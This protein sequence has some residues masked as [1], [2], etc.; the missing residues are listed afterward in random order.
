MA[1]ARGFVTGWW[2]AQGEDHEQQSRKLWREFTRLRPFW[3]L[4]SR[5]E[6]AE[7]IKSILLL[8]KKRETLPALR[9][10]LKNIRSEIIR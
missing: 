6:D 4:Y 8:G 10:I 9:Q 7:K 3:G 1:H 2:L 5:G